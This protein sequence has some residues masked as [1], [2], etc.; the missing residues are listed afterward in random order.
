LKIAWNPV[1]TQLS[2][3]PLIGTEVLH[4]VTLVLNESAPLSLRNCVV[5]SLRM[6]GCAVLARPLRVVFRL[7]IFP[8][9]DDNGAW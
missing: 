8:P 3:S 7:A 1:Q 6:T 2:E 4:P 9:R 5:D